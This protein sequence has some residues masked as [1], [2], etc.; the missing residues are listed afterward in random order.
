M[1]HYDITPKTTYA[2][3]IKAGW[4]INTPGPAASPKAST[5]TMLKT[6]YELTTPDRKWLL[7][8]VAGII[9]L[10]QLEREENTSYPLT[11]A[12]LSAAIERL[13]LPF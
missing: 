2:Q 8:E 3:L 13:N 12:G 6:G 10:W 11:A 1:T 4:H 5:L 9:G 7:R